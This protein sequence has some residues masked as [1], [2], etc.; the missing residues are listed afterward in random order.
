MLG[1][2]LLVY[3]IPMYVLNTKKEWK[4][5]GVRLLTYVSQNGSSEKKKL[6]LPDHKRKDHKID[7][8]FHFSGAMPLLMPYF[9]Q[10]MNQSDF[11]LSKNIKNFKKSDFF[12]EFVDIVQ[13]RV[14]RL[15][16]FESAW[17]MPSN[18]QFVT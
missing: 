4:L 10:R 8:I 5:G 11:E 6:C 1:W 2:C 13:A 15:L 9:C 7:E 18:D 17:L 3:N 12:Y 16:L 14:Y